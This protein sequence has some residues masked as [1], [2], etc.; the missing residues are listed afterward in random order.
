[1]SIALQPAVEQ[2]KLLRNKKIS[3]VELAEEHI[4]RIER[5]NPALN[6]IV[7]FDP[8]KVL[9]QARAV[10]SGELAGLPITIKSSISVAGY[11]CEVGSLLWRDN[12]AERDAV[13]VA[14]L[15]VEGAVILGTT[16]CPEFLMAYET[17]NLLHGRTNNPWDLDR[18]AGGSSGGEAAAIAAGLSAAG[19]G[20]DSGGSV[21]EP[22]HFSGI[23]ALKPTAG[24]ISSIGH[25]PPCIGPFSTLGAIGPMAR[26]IADV[27]LLLRIASKPCSSDPTGTPSAYRA[28]TM[29][30][31]KRLRIG[32]LED[33]GLVP[34]TQETRQAVRDAVGVLRQQGFDVR[35]YRSP[36]LEA[37]R[38]LWD[39]FFVQC[40]AMFYDPTIAGRRAELSPVFL[41][42]LADA[43][44]RT[45]LT[46]TTLLQAWAEMDQVR[47]NLLSEMEEFPILLTPV[48]SVPA[49]R[50]GE[51]TWQIEGKTVSYLDAM[52][53]TQWF[54]L[55]GAPAAVVPVGASTTG[56]PIGIQIAGRPFSDEA[57]LTVAS[58]VEAAF[59]YKPPPI[60]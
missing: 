45:P 52:R 2:L 18:T 60:A 50:H 44:R 42:F 39:I 16:N 46:A 30:E 5:L 56:L 1:M 9:A 14:R 12:V 58:V 3:P 11:R 6:A 54:N 34:V 26:S 59:G 38:K 40:G 41:D 13:A 15:R 28:V 8:D 24:R 43:E 33:D 10:K 23:C 22:A 51:R 29:L 57:V 35:E 19:L 32:Y 20:S 49:F 48:C 7:N 17:D 25:V 37:A 31:A 53:Y 27:E 47:S 4:R 55:L 36:S 21:R